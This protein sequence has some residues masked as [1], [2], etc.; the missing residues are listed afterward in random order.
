MGNVTRLVKY[1]FYV[2]LVDTGKSTCNQSLQLQ[3]LL[4]LQLLHLV[5]TFAL[6]WRLF[7]IVTCN[8]YSI[9]K[10]KSWWMVV[11]IYSFF[12]CWQI[13]PV[14]LSTNPKGEM[15]GTSAI[16][17]PIWKECADLWPRIASAANA[18]LFSLCYKLM[19]AGLIFGSIYTPSS[20]GV[21]KLI[22]V[23]LYVIFCRKCLTW[24]IIFE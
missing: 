16:T 2:H 24:S 19:C 21:M 20:L 3:F 11:L 18:K 13:M 12:M 22:F 7:F 10:T 1:L 23:V 5:P 15:K 9:S 6:G 8:S 4:S 17:G 14:S